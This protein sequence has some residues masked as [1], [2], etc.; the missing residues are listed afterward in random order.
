[1]TKPHTTNHRVNQ[2]VLTPLLQAFVVARVPHSFLLQPGPTPAR[3]ASILRTR[4]SGSPVR[5]QTRNG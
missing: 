4:C 5:L 3:K 1:M 2:R